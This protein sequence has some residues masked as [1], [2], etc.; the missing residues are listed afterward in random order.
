MSTEERLEAAARAIRAA[1]VGIDPPA[2]ASPRIRRRRPWILGLAVGTAV[3]AMFVASVRLILPFVSG[4]D[5]VSATAGPPSCPET[6]AAL[7]D[8]QMPPA[9]LIGRTKHLA[10]WVDGSFLV[11][12]GSGPEG[13]LADGAVYDLDDRTWTRLDSPPDFEPRASP[14]GVAGG[15]N[16]L[17]TG[18]LTPTTSGNA[19]AVLF[20][21]AERVWQRID[22]SPI[23]LELGWGFWTG[24]Q[25]V[26]IGAE[27]DSGAERGRM[28][29]VIYSV[30][31]RRWTVGTPMPGS[32]RAGA[33]AVWTGTELVIW[34]GVT[35][36]DTPGALQPLATGLAY[37]VSSD[38]WRT[39][40]L[41]PL[42]PRHGHSAT[43][44]GSQ[45]VVWGGAVDEVWVADYDGQRGPFADGA[46]YDPRSDT[47]RAFSS[48]F[49]GRSHHIAVW[50]GSAVLFW[51]G[52]VRTGDSS[53]RRLTDAIL[54]EPA[55]QCWTEVSGTLVPATVDYVPA[56][57]T[58]RSLAY[59]GAIGDRGPEPDTSGGFLTPG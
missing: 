6:Q 57:W 18:G 55:S 24:E 21:S 12:G 34:G 11:W 41:A 32:V 50:T 39:I 58:G 46:I 23:G 27:S 54:F 29:V 40:A 5:P 10:A 48:G 14:I 43:W 8:D 37:D 38:E 19:Q 44:T 56:V 26:L 42:D 25:F 47:W 45:M 35:S 4:A 13:P 36:A 51:G 2:L 28:S 22:P 49:P 59:W 16:V 3:V 53:F 1:H 7:V 20:D 15:N 17:V 52:D 31:E 9:P 30:G 33:S